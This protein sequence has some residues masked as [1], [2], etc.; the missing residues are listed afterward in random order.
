MLCIPYVHTI[1]TIQY[2]TTQITK[3][4]ATVTNACK[5]LFKLS[6]DAA[7]DA[8]FSEENTTGEFS[9]VCMVVYYNI[10]YNAIFHS[11]TSSLP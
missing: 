9:S 10:L 11:T 7:N 4:G 2:Y 3:T 5:L 8:I 1:L 6:R